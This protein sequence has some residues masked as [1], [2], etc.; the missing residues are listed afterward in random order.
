MLGYWQRKT[1]LG[2]FA[3]IQNVPIVAPSGS[4]VPTGRSVSDVWYDT[5]K[6]AAQGLIPCNPGSLDCS[7][8]GTPNSGGYVTGNMQPNSV[9]YPGMAT[10]WN[11]LQV[12]IPM[13]ANA[14]KPIVV[15]YTPTGSD[16]V[17]TNPLQINNQAK[18]R[19][20]DRWKNASNTQ[21][22]EALRNNRM[23]DGP[24]SI[25]DFFALQAQKQLVFVSNYKGLETPPPTYDEMHGAYGLKN[26]LSRGGWFWSIQTVSGQTPTDTT[27]ATACGG[28]CRATC[29]EGMN[30]GW[31]GGIPVCTIP[32]EL[33]HD[34]DS[35]MSFYW[36]V[37]AAQE[38]DGKITV[39]LEPIF[40]TDFEKALD[41]IAKVW[42]DLMGLTCTVAVPAAA[43]SA[44]P[45]AKGSAIVAGQL[46]SGRGQTPAPTPPTP[47][48]P[49]TPTT[50]AAPKKFYQQP[51]FWVAT[52]A[53]TALVGSVA[54]LLRNP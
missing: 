48:L 41:T 39:R 25:Q 26:Y 14:S 34:P 12:P 11:A 29:T 54:L 5:V 22:W 38:T 10:I 51:G 13:F 33:G 52:G 30:L 45:Y 6:S 47:V 7:K 8:L 42:Q 35:G 36:N 18:N 1:G 46:C 40:P 27:G 37:F 28:W 16:A 50:P 2:V 44:N 23:D 31:P 19:I 9:L 49:T 24:A 3:P 21:L 20:L 53:A 43:K 15:Q 4:Y 17:P 32:L